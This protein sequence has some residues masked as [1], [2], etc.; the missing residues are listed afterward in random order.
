[1]MIK[2][3]ENNI[4]SGFILV[5]LVLLVFMGVRNSLFVALAIPFSMLLAFVLMSAFGF[6]LNMIVLFS[7]VLAVGMLVDN[8]IV[9]VENIYRHRTEGKT[10]VEAARQGAA[11]V[12]WPVITSTLTTCAAFS[13]LLVWPDIIGQFMSFL[14][15]T[16]I[17]VLFA[18]LFVAM[19]INPAIC[20]AFVGGRRKLGHAV[21]EHERDHHPFVKMYDRL[22]RR[23]LRHRVVILL[24]AFAFLYLTVL[25]YQRFGRGVEL[26]PDTE[27]RNATVEIRY[28]QGTGI[29]RTDAV[30]KQIEAVLSEYPDIEF[31]LSTAGSGS[32]GGFLGGGQGT[33][34]GNVFIEFIDLHD[35]KESSSEVIRQIRERVGQVA[36]ARIKVDKQEEGPPQGAPVSLEISGSD[37]DTLSQISADVIRRCKGV[38]GLVD[39]QDDYEEALPEFQFQV[40]RHRA[41]AAGLDAVSIGMYLRTAIYGMESSRLRV[42]EEEYDITL[43]FAA[44]DRRS[45]E[46]LEEVMLPRPDGGL[47]PLLSLGTLRYTGGQGAIQRKNQKRVI[48]IEGNDAGRGVDR[49]LEDVKARLKGI[50]LP[51]AYSWRIRGDDEEMKEAGQF[52][53]KAFA[54]ALGLILVILVVQFNSALLPLIIVFSVILSLVGVMWGLLIC[55]MRFGVIMTGVGVI[56]LAGIVVNNAI[57]LV[58]CIR[59]RMLDGLD[60]TEAIVSAGRLR[61]RPVLLTAITTILGLIPMA[62]GYSLE[63]RHWPPR[64]TAG[65]ESSA[66]WAPM[67]VAVIFGLAVAT[68]LTLILVPLMFSLAHSFAEWSFLL[69]R[70]EIDTSPDSPSGE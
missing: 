25:V 42:D 27:P 53:S 44:A 43:R 4:A 28:P 47:V 13:P 33:H 64:I 48:T 62:V 63:I 22:L 19:V 1:M 46:V 70:R 26:F 49:I 30:L 68:V 54:V 5:V 56:S 59:Q 36:G 10:R 31:F 55:R 32:G 29:E 66:W 50:E 7:L 23:A 65:A 2:E 24:L 12:A 20:S 15:K 21:P 40:D 57:V 18:S 45:I 37:F 16:L 39:L 67:A 69:F 58:D 52:L 11:E 17:I 14:P 38:P 8:A 60:A 41:A 35:R 9:I 6:T 61:L 51:R 34:M 3:L